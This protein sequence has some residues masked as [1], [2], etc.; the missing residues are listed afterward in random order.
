[1]RGECPLVE[2]DVVERV[3]GFHRELVGDRHS[4]PRD[5]QRR[6][7]A[8]VER[9][10]LRRQIGSGA[11]LLADVV[12]DAERVELVGSASGQDERADGEG[13]GQEL[14]RVREIQTE[15][16]AALEL[17]RELRRALARLELAGA[18]FDVL[19]RRIVNVLT[20]RASVAGTGTELEPRIVATHIVATDEPDLGIEIVADLQAFELHCIAVAGVIELTAVAGA[21]ACAESIGIGLRPIRVDREVLVEPER[22]V[23]AVRPISAWAD[24]GLGA[25]CEQQPDAAPSQH[26]ALDANDAEVGR[27]RAELFFLVAGLD[28]EDTD[29]VFAGA[30]G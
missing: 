29:T 10:E 7:A 15:P 12:A 16:I 23:D 1:M 3:A 26:V 20:N 21:V 13:P 9:A 8:A 27:R 22:A 25:V 14:E 4:S 2:W 6:L 28:V 5:A 18:V 19:D 11:A 30:T 24:R 17:E